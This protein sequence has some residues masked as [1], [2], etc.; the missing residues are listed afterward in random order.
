LKQRLD[1][2]KVATLIETPDLVSE[3]A[4]QALKLAGKAKVNVTAVV[5]NTV[6]AAR[7]IFQE[8]R[9]RTGDAVLLTGRIRPYD[10]E[11]L[12]KKFLHRL[13]AGRDRK[14]DK[15]LFVVATQTIEVGADLDF[16]ALVTEA[17]PLDALR[18]RFGRLDRL[19]YL[20]QTQAVVLKPKRS[21][22]SNWIYGEPLENTW[23][24]LNQHA[25][26]DNGAARIDFGARKMSNMVEQHSKDDLNCVCTA[27]PMLLPAHLDSW[28]QTNP[29][30]KP[31]PD[32]GPFLHGPD[33]LDSAEVQIVWRADLDKNRR[34]EWMGI[35][36]DAP[37]IS[38]EA[39][40]LPL[41]VAKK[42]LFREKAEVTDSEGIHLNEGEEEK[43][44]KSIQSPDASPR[45]FLIWRGPKT[46]EEDDRL[47]PG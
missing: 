47:R 31:D 10:R 39:L 42:W 41:A 22:S 44:K 7:K 26:N 21:K 43:Q 24:W 19:G 13:K 14:D 36:A 23:A 32:I 6:N 46:G 34:E 16:D 5:V 29:K 3:A 45:L 20:A 15:P 1:A 28:V 2:E 9:K 4:N 33:S 12:L 8:L 37:P 38:T 11:R 35:V 17:A 40:P 25:V 30:P 27:G 18:Q